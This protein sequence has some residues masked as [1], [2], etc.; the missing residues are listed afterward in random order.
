[1]M[2]M[3][4]ANIANHFSIRLDLS[5]GKYE[6]RSAPGIPLRP[7][8]PGDGSAL[9]SENKSGPTRCLDASN[10]ASDAIALPRI[11]FRL[12]HLLLHPVRTGLNARL[13]RVK[14]ADKWSYGAS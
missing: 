1:M 10:N 8:G 12:L 11:A 4:M 14:W 6:L 5:F 2:A 13:V 9:N 7:N 3:A